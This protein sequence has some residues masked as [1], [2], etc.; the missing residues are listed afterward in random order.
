MPGLTGALG[1]ADSNFDST[2]TGSGLHHQVEAAVDWCRQHACR[3]RK[4]LN[5][6]INSKLMFFSFTI[7]NGVD[8]LLYFFKAFNLENITASFKEIGIFP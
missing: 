4:R 3:A 1:K 6:M 2:Q 7:D 8:F 5:R